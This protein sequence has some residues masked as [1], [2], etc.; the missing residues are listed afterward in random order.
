MIDCNDPTAYYINDDDGNGDSGSWDGGTGEGCTRYV[1]WAAVRPLNGV[2][3]SHMW[4]L[5]QSHFIIN[6]DLGL[7]CSVSLLLVVF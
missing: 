7:H 6:A 5:K 3:R 4:R 1:L 2:M